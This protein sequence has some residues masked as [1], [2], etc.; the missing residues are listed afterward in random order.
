MK[1][2]LVLSLCCSLALVP[3]GLAGDAVPKSPTPQHAAHPVSTAPNVQPAHINGGHNRIYGQVNNNL[4]RI[5]PIYG[6]TPRRTAIAMTSQNLVTNQLRQRND[7]AQLREMT[8]T[9]HGNGQTVVSN[10]SS[11]CEALKRCHHDRHVIFV[12]QSPALV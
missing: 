5:Q 11:Y 3:A 8:R 6:Q 4:R 10:R 12:L 9:R 2:Y 1:P 7:R